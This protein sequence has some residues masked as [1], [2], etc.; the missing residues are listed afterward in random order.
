MEWNVHDYCTSVE[1]VDVLINS[2]KF[3]DG[4]YGPLTIIETSQCRCGI[5]TA[6]IDKNNNKNWKS[7]AQD[8][9]QKPTFQPF[10]VGVGS[11]V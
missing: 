11:I 3:H 7:N 6:S 10:S 8:N 5:V 2:T 9:V 4:V 1:N